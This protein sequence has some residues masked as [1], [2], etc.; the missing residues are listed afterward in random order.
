M[1]CW[2]RIRIKSVMKLK[3]KKIFNLKLISLLIISGNCFYS[4]SICCQNNLKDNNKLKVYLLRHAE[5]MANTTGN[6]SKKNQTSFSPQGLKQIKNIVN[7][8][9]NYHFDHIFVSPT[10][11]TQHTILPYLR[12][13]KIVGEI[14]PEIDERCLPIDDNTLPSMTIS[15]GEKI[16]LSDKKYLKIRNLLSSYRYR[17]ND[18]TQIFAQFIKAKN[19]IQEYSGKK[20]S[21]LLVS[22]KC[23][24]G[25]LLEMLL[26]LNPKGRFALNNCAINILEKDA[27]N[28]FILVKY[29]DKAF[30]Q[31]FY[32]K[33]TDIEKDIIQLCL[34]P[35]KFLNNTNQRYFFRWKI[36][37]DEKNIILTGN[38]SFFKKKREKNL[39]SKVQI[40]TNSFKSDFIYT[41]KTEIYSGDK[42]IYQWYDKI[43]TNNH[44]K[45]KTIYNMPK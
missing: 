22:H 14:W 39:L 18:A 42:F 36:Y 5:T 24:G 1:V 6:Y 17:P 38:G 27:N 43:S 20:G 10:Y 35:E 21:L 8:F 19:M 30:T 26:D 23:T 12:S 11:R 37:N 25:K 29:N 7:K 13:Q 34:Y 16:K 44:T 45:S 33:Q 3:N 41:I 15:K 28:Q 40:P 4:S 9:K 31:K 2:H 32:W